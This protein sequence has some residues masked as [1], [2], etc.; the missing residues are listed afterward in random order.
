MKPVIIATRGSALALA[1][2]NWTLEALRRGHPTRAFELLILRTT[3]DKLQGASLT[4]VTDIV[5]PEAVQLNNAWV[6]NENG[7]AAAY[8]Q[9]SIAPESVTQ[10][11][12]SS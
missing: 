6:V 10:P 3:G 2:A 11:R 7:Q 5:A 4:V 8:W 9:K 1:Q 12:T